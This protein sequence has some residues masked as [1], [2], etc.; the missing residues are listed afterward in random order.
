MNASRGLLI[1]FGA[2]LFFAVAVVFAVED[3]ASPQG[4]EAPGVATPNQP[5]SSF[6]ESCTGPPNSLGV[7][8]TGIIQE[9]GICS[10]TTTP[11]PRNSRIKGQSGGTKALLSFR[12]VPFLLLAIKLLD[13]QYLYV[14]N[15]VDGTF[16]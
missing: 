1:A 12:V 5:V 3:T 8:S 2:I 15:A 7:S 9:G 4:D 13:C 14:Y 16:R 6:G 11:E 10:A